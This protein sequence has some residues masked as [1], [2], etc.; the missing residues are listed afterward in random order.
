MSGRLSRH[1]GHEKAFLKIKPGKIRSG[2]ESG[3]AM[4]VCKPALVFN[5]HIVLSQ[6]GPSPV[7][8]QLQ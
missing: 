7:N 1:R 3:A 5:R 2:F 8:N 4:R 6:S